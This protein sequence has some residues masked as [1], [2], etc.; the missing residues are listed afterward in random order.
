MKKLV[1]DMHADIG[2]VGCGLIGA[3]WASM[4]LLSGRNVHAWDLSNK[5][6]RDFTARVDSIISDLMGLSLFPKENLGRLVVYDSLAEIA[7]CSTFIQENVPENNTLKRQVFQEIE[8]ATGKST[9]IASSTSSYSWPEIF[10]EMAHPERCITAHPFNPPHLIPLVEIYGTNPS[11]TAEAS[12]I[13]RSLGRVPVCLKKPVVGH[14]ANRLASALW[15]E[16]VN[17]VAEDIAD[18]EDIDVALVNGPGLRWAVVGAH[19][20]YHLGGGNG[21]IEHYLKHLGPSQE[22]RWATLGNPQLTPEISQKIVDGIVREAAGRS[23]KELQSLRD[24]S[25]VAVLKARQTES[26]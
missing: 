4:F 17:L 24:R 22:H 13:Y 8:S 6:R 2:I 10:S 5:A 7:Q 3:S 1:P 12:S 16:A 23:I 11:V 19:M 26:L 18:V 21:G 15:R 9:I 20:A 25:L 14:I